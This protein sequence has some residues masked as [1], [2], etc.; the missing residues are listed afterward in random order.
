MSRNPPESNAGPETAV[1]LA[2]GE[3]R[4]LRPLT[5]HRPKPMLPAATRPILEHVLDALVDA[6][7]RDIHLIVGYGGDRVRSHVGDEYR[8]VGVTYHEQTHQLGSG[9]AL[10]QAREA[11]ETPFLVVNGDQIVDT[12][13]V[14][15]VRTG[16]GHGAGPATIAVVEA[17]RAPQYGAVAIE[18]GQV[19]KLLE[20]PGGDDYRLL[21]AGVYALEP[22]I[23]GT[24]DSVD[25]RDG[26]ILL[27]DAIAKLVSEGANVQAVQTDAYWRDATYPWDLRTL[28]REILSNRDVSLPEVR[29][30]VYVADDARIHGTATLVPPVAIDEG[31][32]VRAGA[33]VGPHAAI[34]TGSTIGSGAVV[35]DTV[36]DAD[37][38]IGSN[39][40]VVDL[41]SGENVHVGAGATIPGGPGDVRRGTRIHEAVEIGAVLADR[42]ELGGGSVTEPGTIIGHDA[43]V[44]PGATVDGEI[45]S[46]SEVVR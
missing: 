2:A 30:N 5:A 24:L 29:R 21:N 9:H 45:D 38:R 7:V 17:D 37:G 41:V 22:E 40:T 43:R 31:V 42:G 26:S 11:I 44:G 10:L 35:R 36:V 32:V 34:G 39:A 46:E 15:E 14:A 25:P 19:T 12:E 23:F 3:G 28:T 4:R 20:Q 1:V 27:P 33:V 18:A 16:H 6:D 13:M 8:G